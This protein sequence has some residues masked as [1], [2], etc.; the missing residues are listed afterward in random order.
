M[1]KAAGK[2][3]QDTV[4]ES[5]APGGK[6]Y[7]YLFVIWPFLAFLTAISNFG[8]K[9][10]RLIIYAFI[11]YYG[12][13]YVLPT[14]GYVDAVGYSHGLIT[15][16]ALSFSDFFRSGGGLYSSDNSMDFVEPLI[17]F[18]VSRFT[19][20]HRVLFG[21]YAALFG[22]FY[23]KS[24]SFAYSMHRQNPGLDSLIHLIFFI[25]ILPVTAINGVRMWTAAWIFLYGAL[26]IIL[27]RDPRYFII[28]TASVFVHWSYLSANAILLIYFFAGNR[29]LVYLPLAASSFVLPRLL[30]N[31]F[32]R[33]SLM[34]G[35]GLQNRYEMYSGEE[36]GLVLREHAQEAAWFMRIGYDLVFYYLIVSTLIV[37]FG[38]GKIINSRLEKSMFCFLLLF[39]SFVNFGESIPSFGERFKIVFFLF[40]A[41][42]LLYSYSRI[43]RDGV[44][45]LTLAGMFPMLLLT[46][47][48]F[49][50]GAD[51]MS[52]WLFAPG[53]GIPW[54]MHEISVA[55]ILFNR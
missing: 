51:G 41:F 43:P 21:V 39:L 31:T 20:D 42:Y 23:L 10:S 19:T 48:V 32:Q 34:L 24:I 49:R 53:F 30:T 6:Y 37:H 36:Y 35:G 52:A 4:L 12:L 22:F 46:G 26:N 40:A 54:F 7:L 16:A 8:R 18:I 45:Y 47:I 25:V 27:Y 29:E 55:D 44:G 2:Y 9:D 13:N 17:S 28:T 3:V 5:F 11:I 33:L 1:G 15:N 14:E 50:Q 38:L